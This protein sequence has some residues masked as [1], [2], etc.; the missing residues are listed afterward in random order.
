M[1]TSYLRV[2]VCLLLVQLFCKFLFSQW[3]HLFTVLW[4][5]N[6]IF[7][8]RIQLRLFKLRVPGS[9]K[10]F[11][12]D[13][14]YFKHVRKFEENAMHD[15]TAITLNKHS[16]VFSVQWKQKISTILIIYLWFFSFPF[17]LDLDPKQKIPD[18]GKVSDPSQSG[19]TTLLVNL[20]FLP[21]A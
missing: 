11:W 16:T 12:S 3:G 20:F 13:P 21:S 17:S 10:S 7:R 2:K 1:E 18:P 14:N 19:F 6:D 15:A 4:I 5:R 8:N 9:G